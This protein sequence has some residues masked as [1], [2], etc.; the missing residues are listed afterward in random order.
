MGTP[1][2]PIAS[3]PLLGSAIRLLRPFWRLALAA[4]LSGMASGLATAWLLASI[5]DTLHSDQG[6][7]PALLLGF[8]GLC[9]VTVA[10]EVASDLGNSYVGQQAVAV[11]RTELTDR[12]LSAPID[13]ID[14]FRTH[15]ITAVLNHDVEVLSN[16]TF[17]FSSLAIAFAVTLGGLAYLLVLSPLMSLVAAVALAL[18]MTVH[19]RA[20]SRGR[21]GFDAARRLQDELQQQYRA[22]SEGAKEL[23]ISRPRRL[24]MRAVRLGGTIAGIRDLRIRAMRTYMSANAF[25]SILFLLV[26]GLLLALQSRLAIPAEV[27]SGFVLVLLYIKGPLQQLVAALPAIG[28]AQ[29]ALHNIAALERAFANPEDGLLEPVKSIPAMRRI[30]L[31]GVTYGFPPEGGVSFHLGPVDLTLDTGE[32]LFIVG[33]NGSGKTTLVKLLL[34]LYEPREGIIR[35]D[36]RE[37]TAASRDDY[38]QLFSTVFAD[39]FLFDEVIEPVDERDMARHL[40]R[41]ELVGKLAIREGRFTTTDLSTGQRK[42]LALLLAYLEQRPVVVFD[43]WAADQDPAFRRIFYAEL[44]GQLRAQGKTVVVISHDDRY[45]RFADR[46]VLMKEGRIVEIRHGEEVIGIPEHGHA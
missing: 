40:Q 44:L 34:G 1:M 43:E 38:R 22:I 12:I 33:E 37:V 21:A 41:L 32:I 7:T 39:Y 3:R 28:Q 4:T 11:L 36:G 18:G 31:V 26:I 8:A 35:V 25:G 30:E 46:L 10:G 42:R 9:L 15:R 24:H 45:F 27:L 19:M 13:R 2:T 23:R 20:R 6:A 5:N 17:A 16:F 14:R 29:V